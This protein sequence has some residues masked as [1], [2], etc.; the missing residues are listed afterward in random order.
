M[1][2]TATLITQLRVLAHLT[3]T[4]AQVARPAHDAGDAATTSA[5]SCS[6]TPPTRTRA[7]RASAACCTTSAPCPTRSRPLLGRAAALVRGAL[8]QA[9]PLDEALFGRPGPGAPAAR[10]G[11]LRRGRSPTPPACPRCARSPTTSRRRTPRRS[12]GCTGFSTTSRPAGRRR[13]PPPRCSAWP[14]RSPARRNTPARPALDEAAATVS[15]TVG[16]AGRN[17]RGTGAVRHRSG[18]TRPDGRPAPPRLLGTGRTP[19]RRPR[20]RRRRRRTPPRRRSPASPSCPRTPPS[21]PCAPSTGP[22]PP[23]RWPSS[24]RTA[25]G[26]RSSPRRASGRGPRARRAE[27]SRVTGG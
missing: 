6:A 12:T 18:R 19:T 11:P 3:R 20:R 16:A 8:E 14:P 7:P 15:H 22:P 17:R 5:T 9:Q 2:D 27:R 10:P 24:R 21:R 1:T 23:R 13:L 4:E 25:T 26:P